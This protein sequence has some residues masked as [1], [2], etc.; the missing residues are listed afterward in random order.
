MTKENE[1][2][3]IPASWFEFLATG[4]IPDFP[5]KG[6]Y[7]TWDESWN[8]TG[9]ADQPQYSGQMPETFPPEWAP[10]MCF[11]ATRRSKADG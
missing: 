11:L 9:H 3:T 1:A 7:K 8:P 10:A 2:A 6:K 5:A 4:E